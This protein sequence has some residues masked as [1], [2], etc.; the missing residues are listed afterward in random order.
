V[1]IPNRKALESISV[2]LLVGFYE[3]GK[4]KFAGR[5][6][7]GFSDKLLIS[8]V[9]EMEKIRA[10]EC[11]FCNV[12]TAGRNRWDQGLTAAEMRRCTWV[13][14]AMVCQVKFTE[15]SRTTDYGSLF[16]WESG[17]TRAEA[18]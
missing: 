11:P 7:S 17:K 3:G 10:N 18:R 13:E 8:L 4:L 15:W 9:T 5:V 16:S 14:P 1:V 6:G 2:L 12:P